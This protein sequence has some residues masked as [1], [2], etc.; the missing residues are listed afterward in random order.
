[1]CLCQLCVCVYIYIDRYV[2]ACVCVRER[3]RLEPLTW[4]SL[5]SLGRF[6]K[7][8]VHGSGGTTNKQDILA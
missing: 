6:G 4:T 3:E 5:I 8:G 7:L 2:Y 1:M